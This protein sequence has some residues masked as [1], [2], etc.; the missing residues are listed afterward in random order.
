MILLNI[1]TNEFFKWGDIKRWAKQE[2]K[3]EALDWVPKSSPFSIGILQNLWQ[4][5]SPDSITKGDKIKVLRI[6]RPD[7]QRA[8]SGEQA[9]S[10]EPANASEVDTEELAGCV[11]GGGMVAPPLKKVK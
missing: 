10:G 11:S 6:N 9:V 3:E 4:L 5:F 8:V 2:G 7:R 1:T